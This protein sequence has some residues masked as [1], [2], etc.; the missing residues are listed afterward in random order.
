[1]L[2]CSMY[3][4]VDVGG[5]I[6][7]FM[8]EVAAGR[9]SAVFLDILQPQLI[10]L[11]RCV[12]TAWTAFTLRSAH[13]ARHSCTECVRNRQRPCY[14]QGVHQDSENCILRTVMY[15]LNWIS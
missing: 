12:H 8:T 10:D 14:S 9:S 7:H 5:V 4:S 2:P 1:M 6:R 11:M 13:A 3:L 15:I